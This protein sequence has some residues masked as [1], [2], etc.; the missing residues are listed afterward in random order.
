[1]S[2]AAST[3]SAPYRHSEPVPGPQ[4]EPAEQLAH[5]VPALWRTMKRA[6]RSERSLPATEAQVS[7]LRLV[8]EH[9]GLT[10]AQLAD[11]LHVARPTVSNLLKGLVRDGLV[12]REMN[13]TDARQLT[14]RPTERGRSILNSFR[15]ERTRALQQALD[16]VPGEP[17][18]D[19]GTL[20]V[21]LHQLLSRLEG[22]ADRVQQDEDAQTDTASG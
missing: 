9:G 15:Q 18:I 2:D 16:D 4:V 12:E 11:V 5:L 13:K 6:S 1:M 19:V 8:I 17:P 10:P 22:I 3:G 7:I 14:I 21:T 20:V